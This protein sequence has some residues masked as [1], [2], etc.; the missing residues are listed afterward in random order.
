MNT[1]LVCMISY[2][3][4]A[5]QIDLLR[6]CIFK[7]YDAFVL[8]LQFLIGNILLIFF[9]GIKSCDREFLLKVRWSSFDRRTSMLFILILHLIFARVCVRVFVS[10]L[11]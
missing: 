1:N 5:Q 7:L 9:D 3:F 6:T 11:R 4:K 8:I 2:V 10:V